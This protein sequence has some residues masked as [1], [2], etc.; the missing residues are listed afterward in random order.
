[1]PR[2][3]SRPR[4]VNGGESKS[5]RDQESPRYGGDQA[6]LV[7]EQLDGLGLGRRIPE[8]LPNQPDPGRGGEE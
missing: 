7:V 6:Q 8:P 1:M 2:S 4:E 3:N 5:V